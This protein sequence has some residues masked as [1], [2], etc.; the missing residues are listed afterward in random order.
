MS[1]DRRQLTSAGLYAAA[2]GI[3]L[4]VG[5]AVVKQS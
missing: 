3:V 1:I 5:W 4:M 2:F